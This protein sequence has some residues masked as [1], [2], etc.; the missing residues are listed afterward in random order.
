MRRFLQT[1]HI[2]DG[3]TLITASIV[4]KSDELIE[5]LGTIEL[6]RILCNQGL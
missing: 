5:S 4:Q 3:D 1:L 2:V 6:I